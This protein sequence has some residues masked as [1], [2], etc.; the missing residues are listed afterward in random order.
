MSLS[1]NKSFWQAS[2]GVS[3]DDMIFI[4]KQ[5]VTGTPSSIDFTSGI[6]STYQTYMFL[7]EGITNN[8][9]DYGGRLKI[10]MSSD[11]GGSYGLNVYS[12]TSS[13][14]QTAS[15]SGITY[16]TDYDYTNNTDGVSVT[17]TGVAG[18]TGFNA[19]GTIHLHNPSSSTLTKFIIGRVAYKSD[20]GVGDFLST[21]RFD[22]SNDI[23]AV[24]FDLSSGSFT[25]GSISLYGFKTS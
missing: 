9:T 13:N 25:A 5:T 14:Y 6:D 22:Y 12:A 15:S 17:G 8:S 7:L 19:S 16:L 23:D 11:G 3:I 21:A 24:K 18:D 4:S 1:L 20:S 2:L 10:N